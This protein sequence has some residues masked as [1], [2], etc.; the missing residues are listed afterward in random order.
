MRTLGKVSNARPYQSQGYE[1]AYGQADYKEDAEENNPGAP[2][3]EQ[4]DENME[5]AAVQGAGGQSKVINPW[6]HEATHKEYLETVKGLPARHANVIKKHKNV[7]REKTFLNED[8]AANTQKDSATQEALKILEKEYEIFTVPDLP[9]TRALPRFD[10]WDDDRSPEEWIEWCD[11]RPGRSHALSP[12]YDNGSYLWKPVEVYKYDSDEKKYFVKVM[13]TGQEKL[14]TRLSLLFFDE[15]PEQFRKRV[16]NCK[17]L[18]A[19]VEAELRFTD[20]V[21][22]ISSDKVSILSKERRYNFL[23]KC[24]RESD[25]FDP[26]RVYAAFKHLMRVVEEEYVRQMK[27]C[28]VLK[29]MQDPNMASKF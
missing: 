12:V 13:A 9:S 25:K 22:S 16:N 6:I 10:T 1:E 20:L 15:D 23:N 24:V 5:L 7:I 21:D 28:I 29:E 8:D 17:E 2:E 26:D 3:E 4:K 14:V 11:A 19:Q 18:Q 27:K